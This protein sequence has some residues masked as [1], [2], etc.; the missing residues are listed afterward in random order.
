MLGRWWRQLRQAREQRVL[1]RRAIPEPLWQ[2]TLAR[3]PFLN[4]RDEADMLELRRLSTLFL[5]RKEFQGAG[6]FEVSDEAAVAVAAQACLPVLKLG[7]ELYDGFVGIVMHA[8]EVLARREVVDEDGVVH[9]YEERLAGEAMDGGPV[10]LSWRDVCEA[11][12][13][14]GLGY[15]VV[16]HEFA[17]V[18]DLL[19]GEADGM[20]PL[21]TQAQREAWAG[22]IDAAYERFC[23]EVDAG[24]DTFLDPY[25]AEGIDE[26]FAVASESFFVSPRGFAR[27]HPELYRLLA[28]YFRQ[29]PAAFADA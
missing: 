8:D 4:W 9:Q 15:N 6:G 18:L 22:T 29:D 23:E 16:V 2:L 5:D 26:F 25:G 27:E 7:I 20:P 24:L 12:D 28:G 19:D 17:H 11:G 14:A 21:P 1:Q 13:S 3:F 10:M